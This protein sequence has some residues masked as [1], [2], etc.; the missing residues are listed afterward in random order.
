LLRALGAALVLVAALW[1]G[2]LATSRIDR[3]RR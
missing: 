1:F 2:A 3:V